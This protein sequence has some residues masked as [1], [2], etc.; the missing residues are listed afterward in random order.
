[1]R[2]SGLVKRFGERRAVDRVDVDLAAGECLAVLG[3]ERGRQEHAA[4]HARHAAAARRGRPSPSAATPCPTEAGAGAGARSATWATTRWST[5]TSRPARTWSSTPTSTAC[6]TRG[7]RVDDALD[8]VGPAGPLLRPGAHLQ[9][10]HGPAARPGPRPP[11][12]AAPAAAGR[13]LRRPRRGRGPPARRRAGRRRAR[14][15]GGDRHPRGRAGRR[16][17]RPP[18]GAARRPDRARRSPPARSTA[19]PSAPATR[20]W[21]RDGGPPRVAAPAAR[22]A[23]QGPAAGAAHPRHDRGD[24]A[25]RRRRDAD[26]PVRLRQPRRRPDPVR[27]AGSSGRRCR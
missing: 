11:A 23:A 9:P 14:P 8:R 3:P 4:A 15:G 7:A 13:A 17:G 2:A 16:A 12:R 5:S 22:A 10:R 18:A 19:P 24:G 26:L 20:S 25:L 27:R 21:W 1:M 6:P